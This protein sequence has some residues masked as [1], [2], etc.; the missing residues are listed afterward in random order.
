MDKISAMRAFVRVVEAGTFT[1]AADLLDV[2]KPQVTRLVQSLEDDLRIK[3]LN[4]TTR[5]VVVT[6]EG[7]AYF[8]RAVRVL[9][10]IEELE[11]SV[12]R[13][14]TTPRGRLR[15][16][17]GLPI[18][19]LIL[20]PALDEFR[21]RYPEIQL[22]MGVTER[23]VDLVGEN[24]DCVIRGGVI[25]DASLV[26]RRV[27][28]MRRM[29][30]ASPAYLERYGVPRHPSE[31]E[32]GRHRM[33]TY[34]AYGYARLTYSL[35][36]GGDTYEV[37]PNSSFAVNDS[38]SML[39]AA[40]AGLGIGRTACFMAAPHVCEGRLQVVLPE[41]DAGRIPLYVVYPPNR[42]V[43]TRLRV[44]IEWAADLIAKQLDAS[45]A[46][47]LRRGPPGMTMVELG[48]ATA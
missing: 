44:F 46:L 48:R 28:E 19:N 37:Q 3:L 29:L 12:T 9:D 42:H 18:A 21:A 36:R 47:L 4:R 14:K 26:A 5:R 16:D 38:T 35:K 11:S 15:V 34:F 24:I 20:I 43:S 30:C 39:T 40:L 45:E 31:L 17:V 22:E 41:W 7:E 6:T 8:Q 2:P 10:D 13:A 33:L 32:D 25:S 27:G 1:K 23:P